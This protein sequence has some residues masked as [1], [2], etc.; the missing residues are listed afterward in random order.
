MKFLN[1]GWLVKDGFEVNYATH[2]YS[3]RQSK[4]ILTLYAPFS[5]INHK[6][7]H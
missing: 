1:G 3:T 6:G 5:Y 4:N 2:V 7:Q